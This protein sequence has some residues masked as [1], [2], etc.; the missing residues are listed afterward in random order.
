MTDAR[1]VGPFDRLLYLKQLPGLSDLPLGELGVLAR[2]LTERQFAKGEK[3]LSEGT[4]IES[5][6]VIVEGS[7][8]LER[9]GQFEEISGPQ[10]GVGFMHWL[11]NVKD[12]IDAIAEKDV[13]ALEMPSLALLEI[14]EDH[15]S[16][17]LT[18]VQSLSQ[19]LHDKLP[20]T[21]D[22]GIK[23]RW[24]RDLI[25][26]DRP[27][28]IVERIVLLRRSPILKDVGLETIANLASD[29][30]EKKYKAN[31]QLW[32]VGDSSENFVIV[33]SGRIRCTTPNGKHFLAEG[34]HF[35]GAI[36]SFAL[37]PYWYDAVA[38]TSVTVFEGATSNFLDALEDNFEMA[39]TFLGSIAEEY[40]DY[41]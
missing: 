31:N 21:V 17:Y 33:L 3:L 24:D 34:G 4:P 29:L 10:Q 18:M 6:Y 22:G 11:A 7:V 1:F 2:Q 40:L 5:L 12:G 23:R 16:F 14:L 19:I 20:N 36:E 30:S 38:E 32:K 35:M 28:D 25:L 39:M 15:F 8:R 41:T 27:L 9:E 26:P 37:K 13:L